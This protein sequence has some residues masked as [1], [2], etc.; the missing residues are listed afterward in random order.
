MSPDTEYQN[1][2]TAEIKFQDIYKIWH[3]VIKVSVIIFLNT[4]IYNKF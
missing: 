2:W 3:F 1:T 4:K